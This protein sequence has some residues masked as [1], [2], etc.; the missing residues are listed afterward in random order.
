MTPQQ[1]RDALDIYEK[2]L[3]GE[4]ATPVRCATEMAGHPDSVRLNHLLWMVGET[5][6]FLD[7]LAGDRDDRGDREKAMRWLGFIQGGLWSLGV[8]TIDE[9]KNHN[10]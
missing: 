7:R 3:K 1:V 5:R 6:T 8:S 4:E 10:R 2:T 9:M